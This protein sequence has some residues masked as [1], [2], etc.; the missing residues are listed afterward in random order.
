MRREFFR[1]WI[2]ASVIAVHALCFFIIFYFKDD[3]LT[4][5]QRLDLAFLLMPVSAAY[6]AAIV[7]SA[8]DN[9]GQFGRGSKVNLNYAIIISLFTLIFLVALLSTVISIHEY[10]PEIRRQITLFEIAFGT[11]FGLIATDLFGKIEKP[12]FRPPRGAE[13]D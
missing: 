12:D 10:S 13:E 4:F 11:G 3:Y 8:V 6:V 5:N 1:I 7:R 2:G 9:Q